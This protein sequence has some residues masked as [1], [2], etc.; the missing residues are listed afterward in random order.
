MLYRVLP[1]IA[2][3]VGSYLAAKLIGKLRDKAVDAM[4]ES[5]TKKSSAP[6]DLG[7]LD[8]DAETDSYRPKT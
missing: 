2:A 6:K 3:T 5:Q 4:A 1:A 7:A 8:Y